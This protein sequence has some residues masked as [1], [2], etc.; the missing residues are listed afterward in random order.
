MVNYWFCVTNGENWKTIKQKLIWGIPKRYCKLIEKVK[1]EDFLV[2]YLRPKRI[3]GIF[4]V[5]SGTFYDDTKVFS[6]KGF[7]SKETFPRRMKVKPIHVLEEPIS[8]EGFIPQLK[9]IISK[10]KWG[11]Y[12]RRAMF[13]IPKEDYDLISKAIFK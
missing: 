1:N 7:R 10:G 11:G 5:N 8:I 9:F 12:F 6:S 4:Q 13:L 2:F 3:A